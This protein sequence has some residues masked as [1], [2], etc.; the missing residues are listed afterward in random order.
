MQRDAV[1]Q[2][3]FDFPLLYLAISSLH[4]SAIA[5]CQKKHWADHKFLCQSISSGTWYT[6]VLDSNFITVVNRHD[7]LGEPSVSDLQARNEVP[8]NIYGDSYHMVKLQLPIIT[9]G[10]P[11]IFVHDKSTSFQLF[12][13]PDNNFDAFTEAVEEMGSGLKMYRWAQRV[14]DWE[15]KI[16][17]DREPE[18]TP[19]W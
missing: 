4:R 3:R 19:R 16:C 17:L 6:V 2:Q 18:P 9:S 5:D 11:H 14:G 8:S 10:P 15:W 1:L 7:D 13:R 12:L